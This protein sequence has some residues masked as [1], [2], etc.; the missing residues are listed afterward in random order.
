M[1]GDPFRTVHLGGADRVGREAGLDQHLGLVGEAG[2]GGQHRVGLLVEQHPFT[3]AHEVTGGHAIAELGHV[4]LAVVE[5]AAVGGILARHEAPVRHEL[6]DVVVDL[7]VA[8][9]HHD[10][11]VGGEGVGAVLVLETTERGVLDRRRLGVEGVDL[12]H[13]AEAV[14][15]VRFLGVVEALVELFPAI[16]GAAGADA[17]APHRLV[18]A[19][20]TAGG[21]EVT[22]EVLFTGEIRAPG[23]EAVGA[24]VQRAEHTRAAGVGLG[25]HQRVAGGR[26]ADLHRR[27][28]GDAAVVLRVEDDLPLVA[29]L[30]DVDH[31]GAVRVLRL[32]HL[33]GGPRGHEVGAEQVLVV[34]VLVVHHQQAFLARLAV[35]RE[36]VHAVVVVADLARLF[37][38][39]VG[40]VRLPHRRVGE[41]GIAPGRE[42]LRAVAFGNDDGVAAGGGDRREADLRRGARTVVAIA[43]AHVLVRLG[44]GL[45]GERRREEGGGAEAEAALQE[46]AARH[47]AVHD[48][49]EVLV[50]GKVAGQVVEVELTH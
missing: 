32:Q 22:V 33:V 8:H 12:H 16:A 7:V 10:A 3:R 14:R 19:I 39:G 20:D 2:V 38:A 5:Q 45:G 43:G 35:N 15:F 36:E 49:L 11:T 1:H 27:V 6:V 17:I 13:P 29:V 42:G 47:H 40:A 50:V 9:V 23:R 18:A 21:A 31:R 34:A 4:E 25:L 37:G 41:Q 48:A 46:A 28:A 44:R 30:T 24:V 26:A